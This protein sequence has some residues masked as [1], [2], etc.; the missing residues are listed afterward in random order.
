MAKHTYCLNSQMHASKYHLLS[1]SQGAH[2]LLMSVKEA[3][4]SSASK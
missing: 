3:W 2:L 1:N 4:P